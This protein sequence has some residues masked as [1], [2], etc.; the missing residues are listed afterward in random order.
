MMNMVGYAGVKTGVPYPV[1]A[2]ASFGIWGA[3]ISGLDDSLI[4]VTRADS[5][6]ASTPRRATV[7]P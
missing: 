4:N 1:L 7:E 2:R 3:N 6:T 5:S